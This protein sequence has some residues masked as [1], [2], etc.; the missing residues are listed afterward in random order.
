MEG[1]GD[2][3]GLDEWI[4]QS[5]AVADDGGFRVCRLARQGPRGDVRVGVDAAWR[6]V[7]RG[8]RCVAG[9]CIA[10]V[11]AVD[12]VLLICPG[13]VAARSLPWPASTVVWLR[14]GEVLE[15]SRVAGTSSGPLGGALLV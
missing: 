5:A 2:E 4:A 3:E 12:A 8:V 9:R 15:S 7:E 14:R 11:S 13:G 10:G 6:E 1:V